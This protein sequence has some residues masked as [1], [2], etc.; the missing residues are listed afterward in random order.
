MKIQ[1]L[2]PEELSSPLI[3]K[4]AEFLAQ[5]FPM[6]SAERW[7]KRFGYWWGANPN[8]LDGETIGWYLYDDDTNSIS[9]FIGKIPIPFRYKDQQLRACAGT[10]WYV[11]EEMRGIQST[12]LFMKYN[13]EKNADLFL[14][15]TPTTPVQKMLPDIGFIKIGGNSISNYMKVTS[16]KSFLSMMSSLFTKFAEEENGTK[17]TLFHIVSKST[18]VCSVIVPKYKTRNSQ[19]I[20]STDTHEMRI[21]PDSSAFIQYLPLHKKGDT[22]ELSKDKTTLDWILFSPEVQAL[23]RRTTAQIFTKTGEYCG[24]FI[25]DIQHVGKDTTLRIRELQLLKPEDA[26]IK[27][28]LKHVK[29]EAKNAGCAAVY[30]GLQ[31]PDPAV[32]KLL[33]KH[34]LL[35]LKTDNRYYVKF[36][37]N[38]IT[39][40]DPYSI[41]VPSDLDPDVGFI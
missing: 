38:V 30:S 10:S 39:D 40:V 27:L 23:L 12:R 7:K 32:D 34:I 9:G 16:L 35:S 36:R 19:I 29:I 21:C 33:H 25:Y 31:N 14:D 22:I 5:G 37:K 17:Q 8:I 3:D 4:L 2:T 26:V 20:L 41:Y 28:I 1:T 18:A 15:T 13:Q 24:Y 11:T 6:D